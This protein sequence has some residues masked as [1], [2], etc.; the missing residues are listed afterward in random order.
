MENAA[1]SF[2]Q[3]F[4]LLGYASLEK[5]KRDINLKGLSG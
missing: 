4:F 3:A 5:K 2:L 1:L